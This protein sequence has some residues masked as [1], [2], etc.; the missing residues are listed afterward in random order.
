MIDETA[1]P[2]E[3]TPSRR[4][5][6]AFAVLVMF[7]T[8]AYVF[9]R[10]RADPTRV[11]DFDQVWYAAQA[12]WHGQDPYPLIG[13]GRAFEWKWPFYYPLPA[14]VLVGPLG[15]GSVLLARCVFAGLSAGAL[16]WA[17]TRDGWHR[18][19]VFAS[20]S[21]I[22]SV[23]LVQW[24]P[25]LTAA[26]LLPALSWV[27][28][29]KPNW[30]VA[31]VAAA[32]TPRIWRPLIIG[33]CLLTIV[34]F[35]VQPGWVM[36]WLPIVRSASHFGTPVVLPFGFLMLAVLLRWRRP[37]AR[38][39]LAVACLPQ[40]PGFYDALMLFTIPRTLRESLLLT[41][42][43]YIVFFAM[44]FRG[45]WP[46]DSAWMADIARFTLWFLYLPCVVM[47]LRRPNEGT[48]PISERLWKKR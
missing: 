30:G 37:E 40:T 47:V 41:G 13:L 32:S 6:L 7:A 42:C 11:S 9:Q 5:R 16:A 17:I 45:P 44:A 22:V 14:V 39:L 18:T 36:A 27:S 10:G 8:A 26:L 25:L 35:I 4:A 29:A 21:F 48:L 43:S 28:I 2:V 38:L 23:Q 15:L 3:T 33:T 46:A 19:P 20:V 31:I 34:A 1:G 24:S 12:L